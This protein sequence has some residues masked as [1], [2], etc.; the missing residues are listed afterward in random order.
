MEKL[1]AE[2][3]ENYCKRYFDS[4]SGKKTMFLAMASALSKNNIE[5]VDNALNTAIWSKG[6]LRDI[7]YI[8]EKIK[9]I[10]DSYSCITEKNCEILSNSITGIMKILGIYKMESI[11]KKE[12]RAEI[13]KIYVDLEAFGIKRRV[14]S[15]E[16]FL[17][18]LDNENEETYD[19]PYTPPERN[20]E[21]KLVKYGYSVSQNSSLSTTARQNLLK[22]LI[23]SK[24]VSKGYIVSYLKHMIA[25]NGKKESNYIALHKWESDLEFVKRL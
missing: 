3:M 24:E 6:E 17:G 23:E 7:K 19:K 25:I 15:K 5:T 22:R 9:E 8:S 11:I 10:I 20:D 4:E 21:S 12:E 13:D 2:M 14:L 18:L 16:E 1:V